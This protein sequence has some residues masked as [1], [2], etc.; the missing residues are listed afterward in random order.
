MPYMGGHW[1]ALAAECGLQSSI[2]AKNLP[3]EARKG[4][5]KKRKYNHEGL[6]DPYELIN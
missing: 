1:M 5:R 6:M 3:D 2:Y 4:Y